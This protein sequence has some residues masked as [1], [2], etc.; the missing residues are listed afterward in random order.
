MRPPRPKALAILT[1]LIERSQTIPILAN[2]KIEAREG[3]ELIVTASNLD[4][5]AVRRIP[6][7]V[8]VAGSTTVAGNRF[9]YIVR[10]FPAGAQMSVTPD[11]DHHVTVKAGR[12]KFKLAT[13]PSK[14]FPVMAYGDVVTEFAMPAR[15]LA[16]VVDTVRPAI[17]TEEQRYY[18]C[19]VAMQIIDGM[20]AE[21]AAGGAGYAAA[22]D[23]SNAAAAV[24]TAR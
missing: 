15:A 20:L 4:I 11:G 7:T 12:S 13:L 10:A 22:D 18:L 9:G 19:G 2:I 16:E 14:D 1:S 24:V 8:A 6:C 17:S 23:A 5:E 3:G 21:Q